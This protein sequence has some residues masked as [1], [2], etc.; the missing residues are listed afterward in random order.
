MHRMRFLLALILT[1]SLGCMSSWAITNT[2]FCAHLSAFDVRIGLKYCDA[3]D[4]ELE[5]SKEAISK[6]A[7]EM[8]EEV[9]PELIESAVR[10]ALLASGVGAIGSA[11]GCLIPAAV[12]PVTEGE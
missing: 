7:A 6:Q 3:G 9:L 10:A 4:A 8:L 12:P 5:V 2:G 11:A 1:S